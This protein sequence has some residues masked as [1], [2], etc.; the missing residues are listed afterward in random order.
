MPQKGKVRRVRSY[1]AVC[2]SMCPIVCHVENDKLVRVSADKEHPHATPL[3]PKGLAGPELVYDAQRLQYPLRRTRPKDDPDPGW[4][5]I[6]WDEALEE[7]AQRLMQ[8]KKEQG[9]HA[10]AFNRPGP[11]GSPA[12]DYG[13]WMVRLAN[14]Y[15]SPNTLATG[16]VCQWHRDTG[17]RYTYGDEAVPEADYANT[18]L[19]MIWGHNPYTSVRCTVR[20]IT[21]AKKRGAK[22]VVVDPR[23]TEA[24]K[25]ADLWLQIRPGT[26]GALILGLIHL[27][28][29]ERLFDG[30]FVR[31]WTNA[32]LLVRSDTGDLLRAAQLSLPSQAEGFVVWDRREDKP[33]LYSPAAAGCDQAVEPELEGTFTCLLKTGKEIEVR[34]V[35][36]HLKDLVASY[37]PEYVQGITGIPGE[38]IRELALALGTVKPACYYSYNGLEQHTNAMQ[39]NRALCILFAMTGN[40]DRR[41]GNVF[42]PGMPG[43][44]LR[45]EK[46][47]SPEGHRLR[48]A[49]AKR[50]LGPAGKPNSSAQAYEVFEAILTGEPYPIKALVAFGG[51]TLTANSHSLR[52]REALAR[53]EFFVQAD[54]YMTPSTALADIVLPVSSFYE[55]HHLRLGFP[56]LW[57][58]RKWLQYRPQVIPPLYET[59]PDMEIIFDLA[60]RLDLGNQFWGGKVEEAFD[61]Q[62]KPLGLNLEEVKKHPGGLPVDMQLN[63]EKYLQKD[64]VTAAPRGFKTAS[65]RVEIYSMLFKEH[66]YDPLPLYR[67][68]EISPVSRPDLLKDYPLILTCSKLLP[69]CHGQHRS[70]PSLRKLVP[71]PFVEIHPDTARDYGIVDGEWVRVETWE[72]K[73]RL[74]AKCTATI[75]REVVCVQHGWWQAC[76]ELGLPGYPAFSSEGANCNL[77]YS[78]ANI[79]PITGSVP[80]KAYLCR[81]GKLEEEGCGTQ[82]RGSSLSHL[83]RPGCKRPGFQDAW[84]FCPG[85]LLCHSQVKGQRCADRRFLQQ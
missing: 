79:D 25:K 17:S 51:N 11:G 84:P 48:L 57:P 75:G 45:D 27:L 29:R 68:P 66:G 47:L 15:G 63:F 39:T 40:L 4:K 69:F 32:P 30:P 42:F 60:C 5:R 19:L 35:F 2:Q 64:P 18:A 54:L 81:I 62:L 33:A 52:G 82:Q 55:T 49:H 10:V 13:E 74:K 8:I 71:E 1:C 53:L 59:R 46:L 83:S 72:G 58:A 61:S 7:V 26:D 21:Q 16:H 3:C 23:R 77:L 65:K 43:A 34:P 14:A 38:K 37:T 9:A 80:Y 70:I 12:R 44:K 6:S 50:P 31:D 20:D 22:L 85:S 73:I 78:T 67:E 56:N 36:S 41:G 24:A 76:P 28:I